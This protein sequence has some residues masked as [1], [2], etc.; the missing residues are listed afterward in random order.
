M[1]HF[2]CYFFLLYRTFFLFFFFPLQRFVRRARRFSF[3]SLYLSFL[4][5]RRRRLRVPCLQ[6]SGGNAGENERGV[7]GHETARETG[8]DNLLIHEMTARGARVRQERALPPQGGRIFTV[9]HGRYGG[10]PRVRKLPV[11]GIAPV[12]SARVTEPH[13]FEDVTLSRISQPRAFPGTV[14]LQTNNKKTKPQQIRQRGLPYSRV[15]LRKP[16][17]AN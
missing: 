3:G 12:R 9:D 7:R 6:P 13:A 15:R 11:A 16:F 17:G 10:C 2:S 5:L 1:H 14:L 8:L 4:L